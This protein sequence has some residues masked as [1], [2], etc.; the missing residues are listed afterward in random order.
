V[1]VLVQRVREARVEVDGAVV[2][3][4]G[5]GLLV[6]VGITHGDREREAEWLA[7]KV[8]G[9]RIFPDDAGLMNRDL[10]AVGGAVLSVSQFTLYGDASRGRRPSFTRAARPDHARALFDR[11][12]AALAAQGI[13]VATG[14]FGADMDVHLTNW[15]PVTLWLEAE[16]PA[17]AGIDAQG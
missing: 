9:L 5:V 12:N 3:A 14:R 7:A 11:F 6:L 10:A 8:A 17:A 4:I 16:A 2:G 15:G 1:R 13:P